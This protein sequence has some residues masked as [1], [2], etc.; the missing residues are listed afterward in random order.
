MAAAEVT[1]DLCKDYIVQPQES[2][3]ADSTIPC[4]KR[5][6]HEPPLW[7][8]KVVH[9]WSACGRI[10]LWMFAVFEVGCTYGWRHGS[11]LKMRVKQIDANANVIRLEP[12]TTK[13]RKD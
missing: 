13:T 10:G 7:R 11:L 3:V 5:T 4:S 6:T 1:T 2:G 9:D 8:P 12:G